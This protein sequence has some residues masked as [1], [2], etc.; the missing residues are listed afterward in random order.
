MSNNENKILLA[1]DELNAENYQEAERL[2]NE[3][4]LEDRNN[5][6]AW[7]I[8][9]WVS[10]F[11]DRGLSASYQ[12]LTKAYEISDS[13]GSNKEIVDAFFKISLKEL[14]WNFD[15][16]INYLESKD[17]FSSFS[18]VMKTFLS[19]GNKFAKELKHIETFYL[20]ENEFV[21]YVAIAIKQAWNKVA[22]EYY[23]DAINGYG[24]KWSYKTEYGDGYRPSKYEFE[25]FVESSNI[26]AAL[27]EITATLY[28]EQSNFQS[29][30]ELLDLG[31]LILDCCSKAVGFSATTEDTVTE[32]YYD[33]EYIDQ[34]ITTKWFWAVSSSIGPDLKEEFGLRKT[35]M[36]MAQI[37][38]NKISK[39]VKE[40]KEA[41]L[42][43]QRRLQKQKENAEYWAK[44]QDE[45]SALLA[46]KD[47][48]VKKL[49]ELTVLYKQKGDEMIA[50]SKID[51][52]NKEEEEK[53]L[54]LKSKIQE[55]EEKL[56]KTGFFKF[57]EKSKIKKELKKLN[58]KMRLAESQKLENECEFY[59][60]LNKEVKVM[61]KEC[62]EIYSQITGFENRIKAIVKKL[63]GESE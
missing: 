28:N 18:D 1:K 23:K 45:A 54:T 50:H 34:D 31:M 57:S 30:K 39:K 9:A 15:N 51:Y 48:L 32:Y 53:I 46:E 24:Y 21:K 62:D 8:K 41:A 27:I 3:V 43:E 49:K 61:K 40:E 11:L 38:I 7:L 4:L 16:L 10:F 5:K 13:K 37:A 19:T 25:H 60:M 59:A 17:R 20:I 35:K 63:N 56:S 26:L 55:K 47:V 58:D 36:L 44:H 29:I 22:Q 33:D 42:R 52:E 12:H 6:D 2:V 14:K